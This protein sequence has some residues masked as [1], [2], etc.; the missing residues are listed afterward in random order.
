MKNLTG[1]KLK[2]FPFSNLERIGI[3]LYPEYPTTVLYKTEQRSPL[4]IEWVDCSEQ[5]IDRFLAYECST[6]NLL[7]FFNGSLS[8]KNLIRSATKNLIVSFEGEVSSPVNPRIV[9]F[10]DL[11]IDYLPHEDVF[12]NKREAVEYDK[13]LRSFNL[14][15]E[16]DDYKINDAHQALLAEPSPI[17][18]KRKDPDLLS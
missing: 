4:V 5:N 14:Q 16:A 2:S 6:T 8:H 7:Q 11:P 13:I 15:I 1:I 17:Y 3:L 18:S 12:F 10:E 9:H